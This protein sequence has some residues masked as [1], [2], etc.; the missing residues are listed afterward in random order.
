VNVLVV[1]T[2]NSA[3]SILA[4]ALITRL[5]AGRWV[6]F[7]AGSSPKGRVNPGALTLTRDLGFDDSYF[8]SKSWDEFSGPAAPPLDVV[9]TVCDSA[10][11]EVCPIWADNPVSVHWGLPDPAAASGDMAVAAAFQQTSAQLRRRISQM[12]ELPFDRLS[13]A[14]LKAELRRIHAEATAAEGPVA[15]A[16]P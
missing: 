15:A 3:R 4:E 11:G 16:T 14:E 1:C 7:S 2:G 5:G 8:R 6:G 10:A 12:V 13:P 9:I